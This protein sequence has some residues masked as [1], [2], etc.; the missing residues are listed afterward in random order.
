MK[1]S[2]FRRRGQWVGLGFFM[3]T[4][5][6]GSFVALLG[7]ASPGGGPYNSSGIPSKRY[8]S[9][10]GFLI[11]YT[12]KEPGTAVV[13]EQTTNKVLVTK[14][15]GKG[16]EFEMDF[17]PTEE[18]LAKALGIQPSEARLVLYFVPDQRK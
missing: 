12:A 18:D 10:G 3:K 1:T 5:A 15:L 7:C 13:V 4:L 8:I 17:D 2:F 16:E 9:G 11:E 6:Y 14:T